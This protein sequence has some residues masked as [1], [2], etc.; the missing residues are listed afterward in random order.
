MRTEDR[1]ARPVTSFQHPDDVFEALFQ[2][3][4]GGEKHVRPPIM[5]TP[6]SPFLPFIEVG[7]ALRACLEDRSRRDY[8]IQRLRP[9]VSAIIGTLPASLLPHGMLPRTPPPPDFRPLERISDAEVR[10]WLAEDGSLIYGEF[11]RYELDNYFGAIAPLIPAGGVMVDLGSG[12]GKVVMSAALAF[13]FQRCIGVEL[14]GYRHAMA[15]ERLH[16]LLALARQ[17]LA[18]LPSP[19]TPDTPLRLPFGGAARGS[20]LLDLASRIA[21]IEADM[22]KVDVRGASLVFMYSTCFGPLMDAL[23]DKLAR[24]MREGALVSTTTYALKHPAF[25][26]LHYFP[27]GTVAWTSVMLYQRVG[28]LETLAPA[29]AQAAYEPDPAAW[30]ERVRQELAALDGAA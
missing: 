17:G 21:F 3:I 30:E 29:A 6:D 15:V 18:A 7:Y 5:L 20:H 27:A 28:P 1:P 22:F 8:L 26:L 9:H 16:A 19:L 23:G 25:R 2:S 13:P 14:M 11:Q 4:Q 12:L 10:A 24:E